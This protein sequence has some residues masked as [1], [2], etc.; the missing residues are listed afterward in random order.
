VSR[1]SVHTHREFLLTVGVI[2]TVEGTSPTRYRLNPD[3]EVTR[4][5]AELDG[6]VLRALADDD[7][8]SRSEGDEST[9]DDAGSRGG[10][11]GSTADEP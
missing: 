4:G 3:R 8:E 10:D 9:A 5:L 7:A 1:Q 11:H 6:A 2:E